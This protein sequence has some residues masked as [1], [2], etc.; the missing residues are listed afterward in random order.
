MNTHRQSSFGSLLL[1]IWL[2]MGCEKNERDFELVRGPTGPVPMSANLIE[3]G[4]GE[5]TFKATESGVAYLYDTNTQRVL[6]TQRLEKG[7]TFFIDPSRNRMTLDGRAVNGQKLTK[8][9]N[10]RLYFDRDPVE[11]SRTDK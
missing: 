10:H 3:D 11:K 2:F 4:R 5:M 9:H 7:Q 6:A 8:D 1:L